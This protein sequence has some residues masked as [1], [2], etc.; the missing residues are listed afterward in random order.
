MILLNVLT[1]DNK[2]VQY[3]LVSDTFSTTEANWQSMNVDDVPTAGSDNLVESGGV[4]RSIQN[5]KNIK[6]VDGT[7]S[8]FSITDENSHSILSLFSGLCVD[9]DG[10]IETSAFHTDKK[11]A[12]SKTGLI[13]SDNNDKILLSLLSGLFVDTFGNVKT[14][15]F[16]SRNSFSAENIENSI[17]DLTIANRSFLMP[18]SMI[19]E[20]IVNKQNRLV[21][22]FNGDSIIG[23][24]LED[25]T[26]SAEYNTGAYPP[27]MSKNIMARKFYNKYKFIG[28]DTQF[29][30]LE[31]L[32]WVKSGFNVNKGKGDKN[33]LNS[34]FNEFEVWGCATSEDY[35]QI[36]INGYRFF[37]LIWCRG[38]ATPNHW[39]WTCNLLV[40]VNNGE[41]TPPSVAGLSLPD[42]FGKTD[43]SHREIQVYSITELVATN[44]YTFKIVPNEEPSNVLVWGCEYWN[45]PRLDVV[46][47]A[48]SGRTAKMNY[49]TMLDAYCSDW[50]KPAFII[51]DLL[52]LNDRSYIVNSDYTIDEWQKYNAQL[53]KHCR[54]NGIPVLMI[55]PHAVNVSWLA[56]IGRGFPFVINLPFIDIQKLLIEIGQTASYVVNSIDGQ[57][58]SNFG[59]EF[60]F[61]QVEKVFNN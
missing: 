7:K 30:N 20:S 36:T 10:G 22:S 27:N 60:Y 15:V 5:V 53:M 56:R 28:E 13:F 44:T 57:H 39:Y 41:F 6:S 4:E 26:E 49:D 50:H 23:S 61:E 54:D 48:F 11:E 19:N 35:A 24:Q 34:S 1:F 2:Y 16:D 59:N 33:N 9:K 25:I 17:Y 42:T 12:I 51:T 14:K 32:D 18:R 52:C 43:S 58:L 45:N 55:I 38:N 46:M 29:R 8:N 40:S 31:H 37:K 21:V 47:E 3:R